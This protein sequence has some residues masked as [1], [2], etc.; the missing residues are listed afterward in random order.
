VAYALEGNI[1]YAGAVAQWLTEDIGLAP[2]AKAL[3]ALA[4]TVE[5]TEG[6]YL[7][8]AFSGLGAPYFNHQA[9]A[10]F[11][12]MHRG[13]RK[14]H[15]ARAAQEC[16]AYQVRDVLE[17]LTAACGQTPGPLRVDGGPAGDPFLMQFQADILGARLA[18][19]GVE[20]VSGLGAAYCAITGGGLAKTLPP[21][22]PPLGVVTPRMEEA[23]R[24]ALY[25][26]W[27]AAVQQID[28][29]PS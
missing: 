24:A 25:A 14:A 11:L 9:R 28:Q 5:D 16:I 27:K 23:R 2:S 6:V 10:A 15:L 21:P 7:V 17:A 1:H 18:I 4:Q 12:G 8:P 3:S 20:E 13:T 29:R 22:A 19:G 26:G